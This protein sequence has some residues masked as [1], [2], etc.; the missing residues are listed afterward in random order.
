MSHLYSLVKFRKQYTFANISC[1]TFSPK[2]PGSKKKHGVGFKGETLTFKPF[3]EERSFYIFSLWVR[4]LKG[5]QIP[6]FEVRDKN[7]H[8]FLSCTCSSNNKEGPPTP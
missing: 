6:S 7:W 3:F 8:I 1:K 5:R 4:L 2:K